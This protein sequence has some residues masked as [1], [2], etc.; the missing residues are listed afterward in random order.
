MQ[1]SLFT[2]NHN[3]L[4]TQALGELKSQLGGAKI[5]HVDIYA[6]TRNLVGTGTVLIDLPAL[7]NIGIGTGAASCLF[8]N[9]YVCPDVDLTAAIPNYYF[10]DI[11][12]PTTF[13]HGH[14]GQ[15]MFDILH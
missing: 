11:L 7:E 1:L 3:I 15:A 8:T 5:H 14:Y 6:L 13:A 10:W 9:P 4:L 12:H 2:E